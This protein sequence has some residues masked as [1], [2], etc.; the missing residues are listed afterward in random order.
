MSESKY[1]LREDFVEIYKDK[2]PGFGF[3]GLGEL[4]YL[5]TYS[6]QLD[7]EENEKWYQTI[8]RVV[9]GI[10]NIQK[11]HI[12]KFNL[13]WSESKAHESA[14][15]MYDR[16]FN[17]KFL[18]PGRGLWAMGSPIIAQKKLFAALNNCSFVST[19][20]IVE[21]KAKPFCFM[22]DMSMLGRFR[23]KLITFTYSI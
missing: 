10:Y 1:R 8:K 4:A 16:M 18:P 13:G 12:L 21:D 14:E 2:D 20:N 15:E 11:K 19:E 5:R 3:N 23:N 17:M 9:E 22:M 6:R 7:N